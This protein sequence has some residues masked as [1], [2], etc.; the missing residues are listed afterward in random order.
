[1]ESYPTPEEHARRWEELAREIAGTRH[2]GAKQSFPGKKGSLLVIGSGIQ[3]VSFIMGAEE[4]LR[5]A[6]KVFYTVSN[7]PTQ[8]WLH[9][10]RPDAFDLYV[11]YDDT[12]PR[13][14]TYV[15][16]S[17]AMLHYVRKG[18]RVVTVFYGH[19]GIFVFSTHRAIAIARREGHHA[20][21]K[22]GIS[23]LDCLCADL[24]V[25]PA[26]PG[27]QTFEATEVLVRKRW[28]DVSTHVVLWQVGLIGDTGYRRKGF[29]NDKFPVLVEYL[30]K[31]YG[32]DH[33]VTHY[34][35]ARHPTFEPTMTVHRIGDLLN[36]RVRATFTAIS[37]FYIPPKEA[38]PTDAEMVTRL[39]LVKPGQRPVDPPP[40]REI[41][42][43]ATRDVAAIDEF[44]HFVVPK[45]YQF[46]GRTR[47]AEFL[48]ALGQDVALQ[49]LY[50][51]APAMAVSEE[52]FPGLSSQEKHLLVA[53]SEDLAHLAAK[54]A[55]VPLSPNE[56][57]VVD[58]H[59]RLDLASDFR[60]ELAAAFRRADAAESLNAWI[61]ARGYQATLERLADANE[62]VNASL[63]LPWTGVYSTADGSL[64][65]TIVGSPQYNSQSVVYANRLPITRFSFN[66]ATLTWLAEDGNPHNAELTFAMPPEGSKGFVR[67]I[68]GKHWAAGVVEPAGANLEAAEVAPA[69]SPLSAW[70][71]RYRTRVH[72]DGSV[73]G[74]EIAVVTPRPNQSPNASH[75]TVD[76]NPV[77]SAGFA[78]GTLGWDGNRITFTVTGGEA[79][80]AGH[81]SGGVEFDGVRMSSDAAPFEG[82]YRAYLWVE[83]QWA[84]CGEF[85]YESDAVR[86]GRYHV[87]SA[88]LVR[89][90]LRWTGEGEGKSSGDLRFFIDPTDQLPKF[91]GYL[92]AS[93]PQ[94]EYPNLMGV[95]AV[96]PDT[97]EPPQPVGAGGVP[98]HV[99]RTLGAIGLEGVNPGCHFLWSR[100]QR[101][102]FTSRLSNRLLKKVC[103]S[104]T[105][106]T[107]PG[108]Q[109]EP[110]VIEGP[111]N[112]ETRK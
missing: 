68:S 27:M 105:R 45:E 1:V 71:G 21:M 13:Y 80:V 69:Y 86:V 112:K 11:L 47:A 53:R 99:W 106:A 34:I 101:V 5:T 102:R 83:S 63:L 3:G 20:V 4:Y 90:V 103:A 93:G 9:K 25:D 54:G 100:W 108:E 82:R 52:S 64:T 41:A 62:R 70:T 74:P 89:N 58:L 55:R 49:D 73:S 46:Q 48:I 85:L 36:P 22:P 24:G 110:V 78:D 98:A 18:M 79:R 30:L 72:G 32:P 67:T 19:P 44:G 14:H 75:V 33:H 7:P 107:H 15:Q 92:W 96:A 28:I 2:H 40:L 91:V 81:L 76:G 43:Y 94:P 65:L 61:A 31:F 37:T 84:P 66:N 42:R 77:D 38:A 6:D 88:D 39:G 35:A 50:C 109:R 51:E 104:V 16:M 111:R 26:F 29:I 10:L 57:F 8:V 23:A 87:E 60:A 97:V 95:L 59:K 12:K 17:E 56:R